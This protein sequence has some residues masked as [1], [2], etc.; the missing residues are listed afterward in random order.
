MTAL[1][2][3]V[4]TC[5]LIVAGSAA[6]GSS[7]VVTPTMALPV[8]A[9]SIRPAQWL[10][11]VSCSWYLWHLPF[12]VLAAA[13][14]G[15]D[16]TITRTAAAVVALPVAYA[17][18]RLVENPIRFSRSLARSTRQTFVLGGAGAV[19]VL[20]A[21]G[22]VR[23]WIDH[24]P[25][26]SFTARMQ[27]AQAAFFWK[28]EMRRTRS[29]IEYC[30]GGDRA[31]KHMVV[32]MGDS[33]AYMWSAA[34]IQ[35]AE[36][37]HVHLVFRTMPGCPFIPV[38]VTNQPGHGAT[39]QACHDARTQGTS[40]IAEMRPDAVVLA[41][42]NNYVGSIENADG[43]VPDV[44]AQVAEWRREYDSFLRESRVAGIR[45]ATILDSPT[46]TERP[47]ECVAR[48][49]SIDAC[50]PTRAEALA[51]I[52]PIRNAELQVLGRNRDVPSFDPTS[53][54]CDASHCPL[55]R[56]GELVYLDTNH[57]TNAATKG[58]EP[59]LRDLLKSVVRQ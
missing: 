43:T 32:L 44:S 52:L 2:P 17:A 13:A 29:G 25:A 59:S 21:A 58:M 34:L 53:L 40:L 41:E 31:S 35:A 55:E 4:G 10:G 46:L 33:H 37:E 50:E 57:V 42:S 54:L 12:I 56:N 48:E 6:V 51:T 26:S 36:S 38:R 14:L 16:D 47:A 1:L 5:L 3:V 39:T 20:A 27:S 30:D 49:G 24:L 22:G 11:R 18:H 28:C 19:V 7:A 8:R 9:L 15:R 45:V 23:L